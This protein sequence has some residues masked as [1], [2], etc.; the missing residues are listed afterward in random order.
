MDIARSADVGFVEIRAANPRVDPWLPGAGNRIVLPTQHV[1]PDVPHR[2]IVINL[3]E[4]RL[5]YFPSAGGQTIT[6]PIGKTFGVPSAT[7]TGYR[8]MRSRI[9]SEGRVAPVTGYELIG[10]REPAP[11]VQTEGRKSAGRFRSR[12]AHRTA[13][14]DHALGTDVARLCPGI[15]WKERPLDTA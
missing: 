2:G 1:L 14:I 3:A 5:Y 10:V 11:D 7:L 12:A 15:L 8:R 13:P 4:L 6:F 9:P